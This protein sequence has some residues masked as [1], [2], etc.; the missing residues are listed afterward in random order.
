[1]KGVNAQK[2]TLEESYFSETLKWTIIIASVMVSSFL[3]VKTSYAWI[4]I[5]LILISL[6]SFSMRSILEVD[7]IQKLITDSFQVL[8]INANTRKFVYHELKGIRLDKHHH[9]YTANSRVRTAQ[10]E[11]NEYIGTLEY[12]RSSIEL[13]RS[14]NYE[15]FAEAMKRMAAELQI[16]IHRTF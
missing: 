16:P 3:I 1:M 11:F 12:D 7:T 4:A 2:S 15:T 13:T 14:L 8:W 9:A 6:V 5:F 10:T